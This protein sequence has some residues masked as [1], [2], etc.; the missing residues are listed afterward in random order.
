VPAPVNDGSLGLL[1]KRN[2]LALLLV[3]S[4]VPSSNA[5][6]PPTGWMTSRVFLFCD[7]TS[8]ISCTGLP[9][10]V[11]FAP[12]GKVTD[13]YNVVRTWVV[14]SDGTVKIDGRAY[15]YVPEGRYLLSSIAPE[16]PFGFVVVEDEETGMKLLE[17]REKLSWESS[18]RREVVR[19]RLT[20]KVGVHDACVEMLKN[21]VADESFI[22]LLVA[23]LPPRPADP[24]VGVECTYQ[25]CAEV[26]AIITGKKCGQFRGDWL[27]CLAPC[28]RSSGTVEI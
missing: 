12:E 16:T 2:L 9:H 27:E 8:A 10:R 24:S 18:V 1:M 13:E 28:R 23:I 11:R 6:S 14:D 20:S 4:F 25:H 5:A 21:H 26:L 22:P 15:R 19:L 7:E 3:L 17:D